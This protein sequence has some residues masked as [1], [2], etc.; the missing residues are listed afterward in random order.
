MHKREKPRPTK[1]KGGAKGGTKGSAKEK[2]KPM[3]GVIAAE[4]AKE[5]QSPEILAGEVSNSL[6]RLNSHR[7]VRVIARNLFYILLAGSLLAVAWYFAADQM[8]Q[9]L[10]LWWDDLSQKLPLAG[11]DE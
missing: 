7:R 8:L 1:S 11:L 2:S 4:S 9:Q 6:I 3:K 10:Q 5:Q